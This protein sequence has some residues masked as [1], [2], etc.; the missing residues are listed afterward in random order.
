MGRKALQPFQPFPQCGPCLM[1]LARGAVAL[2]AG[3]DRTLGNHIE[4]AARSILVN[5]ER[6]GWTSPPTAMA[7]FESLYSR[8]L[9]VPVFFLF[10]VKCRPM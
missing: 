3:K 8:P 7:N 6:Q 4:T 1:D 5:A 9:S 10:K 2:A